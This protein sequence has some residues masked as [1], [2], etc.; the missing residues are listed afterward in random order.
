[1]VDLLFDELQLEDA[2]LAKDPQFDSYTKVRNRLVKCLRQIAARSGNG[3]YNR[4]VGLLSHA[5]PIRVKDKYQAVCEFLGLNFEKEMKKRFD[6]W[7][8][9]RNLLAHGAWEAK[10]EAFDHQSLI[11]GGINILVLKAMGFS[12]LTKAN[13]YAGEVKDRYSRI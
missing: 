12:G 4:L 11:A 13:A 5:E 9:E 7:A 6:A 10:D 1:V 3:I 8:A 2:V